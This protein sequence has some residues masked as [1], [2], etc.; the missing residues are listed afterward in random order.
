LAILTAKSDKGHQADPI[1]KDYTTL[2]LMYNQL[3][4]KMKR[5]KTK[6]INVKLV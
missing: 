2:I 6:F 4:G 3:D 5:K 1:I